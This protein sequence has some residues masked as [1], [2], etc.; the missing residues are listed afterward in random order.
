MHVDA[1]DVHIPARLVLSDCGV[2][3]NVVH[4][5]VGDEVQLHVGSACAVPEGKQIA[6]PA[7]PAVSSV[8]ACNQR[9]GRSNWDVI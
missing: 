9:L 7:V 4:I 2:M 3:D 5:S 1:V 6:V 8:P